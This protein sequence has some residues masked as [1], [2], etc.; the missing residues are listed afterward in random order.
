MLDSRTTADKKK[1]MGWHGEENICC[2]GSFDFRAQIVRYCSLDV[3]VLRL[4]A[5]KFRQD[6][7]DTCKIDPFKSVTI[8]SACR[9]FYKTFLLKKNEVAVIFGNGYQANRKTSLEAT[10]WL[11]WRN[12]ET[13]GDIQHG[14]NGKKLDAKWTQ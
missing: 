2:G 4:S 1:L 8:A 10:E 13:S 7:I 6:F 3:T 14:R 12:K 11:E 9:K 5:L